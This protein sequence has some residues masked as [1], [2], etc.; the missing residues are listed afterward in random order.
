M[1]DIGIR[2]FGILLSLGIVFVIGLNYMF[3]KEHIYTLCAALIMAIML[4]IVVLFSKKR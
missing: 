3:L 2:I 1:L 4:N